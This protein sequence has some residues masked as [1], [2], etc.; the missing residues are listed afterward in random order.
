ML[1]RIFEF[2]RRRPR[3][4]RRVLNH[5]RAE[6]KEG[7][8]GKG[9]ADN[10]EETRGRGGV[11]SWADTRSTEFFLLA[12]RG[13]DTLSGNLEDGTNVRSLRLIARVVAEEIVDPFYDSFP[14]RC[15]P[16]RTSRGPMED[17]VKRKRRD[18][19]A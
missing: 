8:G 18:G 19:D 4:R 11:K 14:Q 9:A 17:G 3:R 6:R 1:A 10:I 13:N 5:A 15:S 16:G 12:G 2:P 7:R